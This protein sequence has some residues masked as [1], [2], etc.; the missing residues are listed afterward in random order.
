MVSRVPHT[1]D[2][3][4]AI[5]AWERGDVSAALGALVELWRAVKWPALGDAI[6]A[7]TIEAAKQRAPVRPTGRQ[8]GAEVWRAIEAKQDPLDLPRLLEP[9]PKATTGLQNERVTAM[10]RWPTHPL[11]TRTIVGWWERYFVTIHV[12]QLS[13]V[14]ARSEDPAVSA[15]LATLAPNGRKAAKFVGRHNAPK[16]VEVAAKSAEWSATGCSDDEAALVTRLATLAA[17]AVAPVDEFGASLAKVYERPDDD[18]VRALVADALVARGDPRGEFISL[19]LMRGDGA[20]SKRERQLEEAW[21]DTWLGRLVPC[22][23]KGTRFRRGFPAEAAYEKSGDPSWPEWATFEALDLFPASGFMGGGAPLL[24]KGRLPLLRK[25][26]GIGRSV[27]DTSE[28]VNVF[29]LGAVPW[30]TLGV[31]G[32]QAFVEAAPR[33]F[34]EERFPSVVDF[35]VG[36]I[37]GWAEPSDQLIAR[38]MQLPW[39]RR[40]QRLDVCAGPTG[41]TAALLANVE[42]VTVRDRQELSVASWERST[43]RLTL[44][45]KRLGPRSIELLLLVLRHLPE[46]SVREVTFTLPRCKRVGTE[47]TAGRQRIDVKPVLTQLERLKD[48]KVMN[49][50]F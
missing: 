19:Q 37:P 24:V 15:R 29:S 27:L 7:L 35:E 28:G 11:I 20:P 49:L 8:S 40:V 13:E 2:L 14:L 18:A 41:V 45:I 30:T 39:F 10:E 1:N 34:T 17:P 38:V 43:G 9:I 36:P 22:L 33:L 48:A 3:N 32:V 21:G 46:S 25:V 42:R 12:A 5:R 23:R 50:P 26:V 44:S 47:L 6:A 16:L 31:Q 4:E